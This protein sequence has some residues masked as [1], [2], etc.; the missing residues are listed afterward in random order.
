MQW[1]GRAQ[2]GVAAAVVAA[3]YVVAA[4]S[5]WWL[6]DDAFI[7]FT[8]ARRLAAGEGLRFN[9][10][11]EPPVEGYSNLLW[12]LIAAVGEAAGIPSPE[13]MPVLSALT[14][15]LVLG[16]TWFCARRL[17]GTSSSAALA[18]VVVLATMPCMAA[19]GTG[20]LETMP[21]ALVM[22]AATGLVVGG[23]GR[24]AVVGAALTGCALVWLRTEGWAWALVIAGCGA[25]GRRDEGR[26][27]GSVGRA[28]VL[29]AL[30]ATLAQLGF[31][32]SW[33]HAWTSNASAAKLLLGPAV[34]WRGLIYVAQFVVTW[35]T[36]LLVAGVW[37]MRAEPRR[38]RW[39]PFLGVGLAVVAW[40]AVV[41][42]DYMPFHRFLVPALP[43]LAVVLAVG[44]DLL[45]TQGSWRSVALVSVA[46]LL[47]QLPL[48]GLHLLPD[49][50]LFVLQDS[51][52]SKRKRY[53]S[54]LER[55]RWERDLVPA[56]RARARALMEVAEPGDTLVARGV[57]ALGYETDLFLFDAHG[58]VTR[59]VVEQG[60]QRHRL[61]APGHDRRV[62]RG[63]F[64][65]EQP[66]FLFAFAI[67]GPRKGLVV[68]LLPTQWGLFEDVGDG[69]PIY[70]AELHKVALRG[71]HVPPYLL[72]VRKAE[73]GE[74]PALA[75]EQFKEA[76]RA[77]GYRAP[78]LP[79]LDE[80]RKAVARE[81]RAGGLELM[82]V[83]WGP[84]GQ[85][86]RGE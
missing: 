83:L 60:P 16:G 25:L 74:D 84:K 8:Y 40:S 66:R 11:T 18:A 22:L 51:I 80:R 54:D 20:G 65:E 39:G 12:V 29:A 55:L 33:H 6:C 73:P 63:F 43:L 9:L 42:G 81:K 32:L 86:R 19:W 59:E 68:D 71:E 27:A 48:H 76:V 37:W 4:W 72:L 82:Q 41:G 45:A 10:P 62:Q 36:P 14:G 69:G 79:P 15:L 50:A 53:Q 67:G 38:A 57:G 30:A 58:L 28:F 56:R 17:V 70:V 35:W 61:L 75:R 77:A 31:R 2:A 78:P 1:I 7:S 5:M 13:L 21:L 52:G 44:L 64:L 85:P 49:E 3:L 34:W 46:V 24:A 23:E 26:P 47:Q